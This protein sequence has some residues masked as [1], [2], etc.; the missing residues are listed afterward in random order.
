MSDCI[1]CGR[2]LKGDEIGL[3]KKLV[4]RGAKE[5]MC[6]NCLSEHFEVSVSDLEEKIEQY[7]KMGCTLFK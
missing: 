7:K 3:F 5:Y 1:K 6:I 2:S 4:N